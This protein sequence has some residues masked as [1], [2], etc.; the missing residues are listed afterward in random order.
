MPGSGVGNDRAAF[1]RHSLGVPVAAIGVPTVMDAGIVSDQP[2][3]KGLFI[4]PRDIDAIVKDF[5]K[6][7]AYGVN[8]AI[9]PELSIA[10]LDLLL[11]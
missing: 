9:Q 1:D 3:V 7:V 11:S 8:L 6:V 10:D 2:D 5:S 4:T